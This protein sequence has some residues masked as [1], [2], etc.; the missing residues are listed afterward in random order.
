MGE[1]VLI[2][3]LGRFLTPD[4]V[5]GGTDNDYVYPTDPVNDF[6]LTGQFSLKSAFKKAA[7]AAS[8]ASVIPGPAGMAAACVATAAYAAAG[9]RKNAPDA[10]AFNM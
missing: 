9:D 10:E 5:E 8:W 1:R 3:S 6:D 2:P 7:N 4:P